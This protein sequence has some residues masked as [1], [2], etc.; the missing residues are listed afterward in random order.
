M[1]YLYFGLPGESGKSRLLKAFPVKPG[2]P[3]EKPTPLPSLAGRDYWVIVSKME[4]LDNPDTAPYF[5]TLDVPAPDVEPYG[6]APYFECDGQC[7][8]Q[9]EGP[10]GLHGING[11][12]GRLSADDPGSSGCVRHTDGDITYLYNLLDPR[13]EQI[14]YYIQDI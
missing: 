10:F 12:E 3:G 14:R 1:E 7:N 13:K 6:P 11:D 4:A 5:L 9:M 8:W 2:V